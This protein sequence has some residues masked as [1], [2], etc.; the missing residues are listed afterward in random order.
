MSTGNSPGLPK[1]VS[2]STKICW[3]AFDNTFAIIKGGG[4]RVITHQ[5]VMYEL[6]VGSVMWDYVLHVLQLTILLVEM[7][8]IN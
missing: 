8:I 1:T 3:S 7:S 2:K 5:Q 4:V 6:S